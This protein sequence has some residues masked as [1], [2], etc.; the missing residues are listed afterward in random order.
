M[1]TSV[2]QQQQQQHIEKQQDERGQVMMIFK[3]AIVVCSLVRPP[4]E[5]QVIGSAY[6]IAN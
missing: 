4:D 5:I 1:L 2:Q 3:L 6:A